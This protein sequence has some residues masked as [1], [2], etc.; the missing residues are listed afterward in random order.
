VRLA[1]IA[2][3]VAVAW[4]A[5]GQLL[6]AGLPTGIVLYGVVLGALDALTA[7]GLVLVYR[8]SRVVNFAQADMGGLA[9]AVAVVMVPG[10]HLPYAVGVL[11]GLVVGLGTGLLVDATVVRRFFR[12]PRL[13]LTVATIGVAQVLGAGELGLP[14]L[15]HHLSPL[16]TFTTP[17]GGR[18]AVGPVVFDGNDLLAVAVVP[19]V[20]AGLWWFLGRTD[21]GVAIRAA[22]DSDERAQLLGVP[23]RRLSRTTWVIAPGCRRW[24]PCCRHPSWDPTSAWWPD[25]PLCWSPW[26]RR[27]S[28]AWRACRWRWRPLWAST[29]CSRPSCGPIRVRALWTSPCSPRWCSRSSSAGERW[30]AVEGTSRSAP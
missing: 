5:A 30:P 24:P 2:A 12:A 18:L 28:P 6:P 15:F 20:L 29:W 10:A 26:P 3:A 22:A 7:V 23:V 4:V 16:A 8:A 14:T 11:V 17:I 9:A 21:T 1:G 13:I 27:S 19:V 25:R